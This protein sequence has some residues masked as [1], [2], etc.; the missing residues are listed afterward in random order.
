MAKSPK[1]AASAGAAALDTGRIEKVPFGQLAVSPLNVRKNAEVGPDDE[2]VASIRAHGLLQPLVGYIAKSG[3]ANVLVCAGQ[4]RL[5]ALQHIASAGTPIPVRI[6]DEATAVEVS[7]AE[8]LERKDMN[9]AD[10]VL[11]FKALVDLGT[12]DAARIS[13]R[14]GY[15]LQHVRRRLKMA[16]LLPEILDALREGAISLDAAT[17][18]ASG[19][20]EVQRDIFRKH[21]AKGA[22]RPHEPAAIRQDISLHGISANSGVAKF[23]GGIDAYRAAGGTTID[24]DFSDMFA[25]GQDD[26]RLRDVSIVRQLIESRQ[27]E[28]A[29]EALS[30]AREKFPFASGIEWMDLMGASYGSTMPKPPK[31]SGLLAVESY[32][33]DSLLARVRKARDEYGAFVYALIDVTHDGKLKV[34]ENKFLVGKSGWEA[35]KPAETEDDRRVETPEE[36]AARQREREI[37]EQM[38]CMYAR[39]LIG[40]T[41]GFSVMHV[42]YDRY[43]KRLQVSLVR[44]DGENADIDP[45]DGW[46]ARVKDE[47][48]EPFRAAAEKKVDEIAAEEQRQ[49]EAAASDR[50]EAAEEFDAKLGALRATPLAQ[51]PETVTVTVDGYQLTIRRMEGEPPTLRLEPEDDEPWE[52]E[53]VEQTIEVIRDNADGAEE[54]SIEIDQG[55]ASQEEAVALESEDA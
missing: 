11:A 12:Y 19:S 54:L 25:E 32:N 50:R 29:E 53:D 18:Y 6:V 23:I 38:E 42:S 17:A 36:R 47:L 39:T 45:S 30:L 9:P 34:V 10:E 41:P 13:S 8:N 20:A 46:N 37:E 7:L 26:G 16:N 5:L 4:R 55:T 3:L 44:L 40:E 28:L 21:S 48:L 33:A 2:L 31:A 43:R 35:A 14:F 52:T 24:E 51:W 15:T 1:K 22:W 27:K 49:K